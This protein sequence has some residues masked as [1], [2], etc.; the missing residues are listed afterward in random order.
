MD[1]DKAAHTTIGPGKY[2]DRIAT[3]KLKAGNERYIWYKIAQKRYVYPDIFVSKKS[4]RDLA[5][6]FEVTRTPKSKLAPETCVI[7][8]QSCTKRS[9]HA[10]AID[11]SEPFYTVSPPQTSRTKL[12]LN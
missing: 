11:A 8:K 10:K 1:V 4:G 7:L 3:I 9:E 5:N 2:A 12:R 6:I